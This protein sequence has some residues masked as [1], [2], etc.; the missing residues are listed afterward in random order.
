MK[1]SEDDNPQMVTPIGLQSVGALGRV[2]AK[3]GNLHIAKNSRPRRKGQLFEQLKKNKSA[4]RFWKE[5]C[6]SL[7]IN[8]RHGE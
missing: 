7:H 1:A 5:S 2:Q 4:M 3:R 6:K 8:N